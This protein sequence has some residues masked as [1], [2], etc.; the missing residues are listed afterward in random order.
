AVSLLRP[1]SYR[2]DVSDTGDSTIVTVREGGADV[3]TSLAD[4]PLTPNQSIVLT[5][6][7]TAPPSVQAAV[8]T[9]AF[10]DWSL[11]RDRRAENLDAV[12]YV[13][14]GTIGYEDLDANGSWQNMPEYGSIWLP[15]VAAGWAPYRF[16]Y[17][18]WV[19]PWGWTWIDQ[20]A[21]GFAPFHYGRWMLL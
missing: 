1:G 14:P 16:G 12:R 15:R 5:G 4:T 8:R 17:W 18:A 2:V 6:P 9:D 13:S 19:E 3:A 21:W 11:A 7:G 20:A 10:G